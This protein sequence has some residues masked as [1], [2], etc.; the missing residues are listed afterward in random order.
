[1][2]TTLKGIRPGELFVWYLKKKYLN[3]K[4]FKLGKYYRITLT[5]N[6]N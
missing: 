2:P 5:L 6:L 3:G 1:M 4:S